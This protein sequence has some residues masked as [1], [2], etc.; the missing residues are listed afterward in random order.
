[1]TSL[2]DRP[3]VFHVE[4]GLFLVL[5][6]GGLV[7]TWWMCEGSPRLEAEGVVRVGV[8]QDLLKGIPRGR[9]GLIGSLQWAPLPTL[10]LMPFVRLPAP[11]GGD[12]AP[13]VVSLGAAA[14]LCAWLSAWLGRCGIGKTMRLAIALVFF[15]SPGVQRAIAAGS[16]ETI[17]WLAAFVAISF[18]IHWWETDQLRSLAYLSLSLALALATRYQAVILFV[19]AGAFVGLHLRARRRRKGY[20]EATLIV[21]LVPGSYVLALWLISNWLIMGDAL[22]FLRGLIG[23]GSPWEGFHR[24]MLRSR[25]W[26]QTALLVIIGLSVWR[27]RAAGRQWRGAVVG[28]VVLAVCVP[29]WY[30]A[31]DGH[32]RDVVRRRTAEFSAVTRELASKHGQDWIIYSGYQGYAL[33]RPREGRKV[34][35]L[36]HTLS[37]YLGPAMKN[38]RGKRTYVLIPRPKGDGCWEDMNLR[39][40]G[41]FAHGAYF[42]VFDRGWTNWQLLRIVRLDGTDEG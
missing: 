25:E 11:F 33:A 29:I 30:L 28:L 8:A 14:L 21:F 27:M 4:I 34:H 26:G 36:H 20:A 35:F 1:M 5:M 42:T 40:P 9:Q 12:W 31:Q 10:L 15:L 6:A 37:F 2:Q 22:F 41:I 32:R 16:A 17:L 39:F 3:R 7:L 24:A 13:I 38:T 23:A 19:V 18:L